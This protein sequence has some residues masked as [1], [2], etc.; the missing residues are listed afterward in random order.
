MASEDDART[1]A[2]ADARQEDEAGAEA[3]VRAAWRSCCGDI[4]QA[5]GEPDALALARAIA[6]QLR[7]RSEGNVRRGEFGLYRILDAPGPRSG[8][9]G[10]VTRE[11]TGAANVYPL[12]RR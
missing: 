6:G 10:V 1:P 11:A 9:D 12:R 7:A 2:A 5:A 8:D 4:A 3:A